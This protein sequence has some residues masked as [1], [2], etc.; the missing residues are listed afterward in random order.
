MNQTR[1]MPPAVRSIQDWLG[2]RF[3][4]AVVLGVCLGL[5]YATWRSAEDDAQRQLAVDFDFRVRELVS[6]IVSR[7]QT[8]I[9]VLDGV[10]GLYVSSDFVDRGEFRDY[11]SVQQIEQHFPGIQGIG[12]MRLV[13]R[14][15]REVHIAMVRRDGFPGYSVQPDGERELYAPI[16]YLEPFSGSNLRAFG[17]DAFSE[18]VRRAALERAR[19]TGLAAMTGKI[20]LVQEHGEREQAGFL[21]ALPL[22]QQHSPHASVEQRR[23]AIRGWVYAPFR[24]GDL[25]AGLGDERWRLLG[26][27]IHDG[28]TLDPASRMYGSADAGARSARRSIDI[29]GHRWTALIS[30]QPGFERSSGDKPR[31]MAWTGLLLSLG[32]AALTWLLARSRAEAKAGLHRAGLLTEQLNRGQASVLA[33]AAKAQRS[34][35]VLRSILDAT[36]DGILVDNL[37]GKILNSNRRFRELWHVPEALDWQADGAALFAYLE[38]QLLQPAGF[39]ARRAQAPQQH[40]ERRDVLQLKDGRVFEQWTRSMQL[41]S[42]QA[43]LCSFRDITE[44]SQTEQRE[45]TR[46]HVLELLATGASLATVLEGVVLGVESGNPEMLCSI[47]L[48]DKD[49]K[50]VLVGAAPSLPAFFSAALHGLPVEGAQGSCG[51]AI[52]SG[53]RV[54]AEN[55]RVH[56][57]WRP[58]RELAA[59]AGLGACWSEPIRGGSGKILGTFA[60]YHRH[61]QRPSGAHLALLEEAA[62]LAGIAIEQGQAGLALRAGEARF[63]SLYDNAPVALWEQ[64][65]SAVRAALGEPDLSGVADLAAHLQARPAELRR[66][67]SLVRIL[68]VNAAA[69]AQVG[70]PERT[71]A[72]ARAQ[73]HAQSPDGAGLGLAQNFDDSALPAFAR[74][75]AALAGGAH[76]FAC[77]SS[78][79]RLDGVA[80]QNELTLLV[81]PGHEHSLDFVIVSTL[82]ITERKRMNDELLLLATTDFL[83]G[84]PNR[85]HF[86]ARLDDEHARLQR[87]IEDCAAVLMLD[88]DHFKTIN[89]EHG[90]ASGDA[91][92]RHVAALMLDG[93]RKMDTLGRVGGEEFAILLPGTDLAAAAVFAERLRRRVAD[94]PLRLDGSVISVT[95]SI[96]IA[97]MAGAE[98]GYDAVLVRADKAL[99]CAKRAGRN[100]VEIS[101]GPERGRTVL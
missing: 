83:T 15:Q 68:D 77:E 16:V 82:D 30:A 1:S 101:P 85:R 43:R 56:P 2:P 79:R 25:M 12:Y 89:D 73:A 95:V 98:A 62:H 96:G 13:P 74:A 69:L 26:L 55:L 58:Y 100:R 60:I 63:R 54:V 57:F 33:M 59:R 75:L 81:M 38:S 22:Y 66:L 94:T 31:L 61:P 6:G 10:Q 64:D 39:A 18:P 11:L 29:A 36:V 67:A 46:R 21:V 47:L 78:F 8:Y 34:Q 50:R 37:D 35:A 19:D 48:L 5:T 93:Q 7:M 9:Q 53:Q 41:G 71:A 90:H 27:Q 24:M 72:Q 99:Y 88:L 40:C 84:L 80:R 3:L 86:M 92:L 28:D 52:S 23:R 49:G 32:L 97:A 91:V 65:W 51:R 17:Y 45:R 76:L 14:A 44:S 87:E 42:D 4:S 20:R 70:A